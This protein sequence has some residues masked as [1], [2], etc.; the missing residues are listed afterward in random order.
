MEVSNSGIGEVRVEVSNSSMETNFNGRVDQVFGGLFQSPSDGRGWRLSDEQIQKR[1]WRREEADS[2]REEI[3]CASSFSGDFMNDG[4]RCGNANRPRVRSTWEGNFESDDE[5]EIGER[6]PGGNA[7][8]DGDGE[9]AERLMRSVVGMDST[10]DYEDEEDEYDKV[11]LGREDAAELTYMREI[12]DVGPKVNSHNSLPRSLY[13]LKHSWRDP[14]ANHY[15]ASTRLKEDDEEAAAHPD[16]V[17]VD[18]LNLDEDEEGRK[19]NDDKENKKLEGTI[20][21]IPR[22]DEIG[23]LLLQEVK[24]RIELKSIMKVK[25]N[26]IE[27]QQELES[28][29]SPLKEATGVPG[30]CTPP[31]DSNMQKTKKR[32]RFEPGSKGDPAGKLEPKHDDIEGVNSRKRPS[33]RGAGSSDSVQDDCLGVPD[34]V[35]NPSKY[36]HYTLDWSNDDSDTMNMQAFKDFSQLVKPS[37]SAASMQ[38]DNSAELPR[39]VTYI[40]RK[41]AACFEKM[42]ENSDHTI[43]CQTTEEVSSEKSNKPAIIPVSIAAS[44][45]TEI[46]LP[47]V[48]NAEGEF[49]ELNTKNRNAG[50][51]K[52]RQ[53]RSKAKAYEET[54]G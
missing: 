9:A 52:S 21:G 13:E 33:I 17:M 30:M 10:L 42:R 46:E 39:S 3:P 54:D 19:L 53:Y 15:A 35:K 22:K 1:Q 29:P 8:E 48:I 41:K 5:Q 32:V 28:E 26:Q 24:P 37:D 7:D 51:Q 36:I 43:N 38:L 44:Q 20:N 27:A 6:N 14:R 40:P 16:T 4:K 34:Y 2:A 50:I 45:A 31:F 11:A 47:A 23:S 18:K 12:M 25:Q 49:E